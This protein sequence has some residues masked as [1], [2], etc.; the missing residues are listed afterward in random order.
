MKLRNRS[1]IFLLLTILTITFLLGITS[2]LLDLNRAQY[3]DPTAGSSEFILTWSNVGDN[4]QQISKIELARFSQ[5]LN[6]SN[7][8][9][10]VQAQLNRLSNSFLTRGF[11]SNFQVAQPTQLT[12]R[13]NGYL[14]VSVFSLELSN[15][16]NTLKQTYHLTMEYNFNKVGT[17]ITIY[18][19]I[20]GV[21]MPIGDA[22]VTVVSPGTSTVTNNR[23]G[24][25]SVTN[26]GDSFQ[27]T[28]LN[29]IRITV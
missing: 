29:G 16:K 7:F 27:I 15:S 28:T 13:A 20:N 3:T 5:G 14:V 4:V 12:I 19:V 1:Q 10:E 17:T 11:T 8:D 6:T 23:D 25:Y 2:V 26:A 24:T 21:T 18:R 22:T 9:V